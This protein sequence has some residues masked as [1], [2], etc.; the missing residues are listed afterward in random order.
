[1]EQ[2]SMWYEERKFLVE[3]VKFLSDERRDM[4]NT[5]TNTQL[6]FHDAQKEIQ[7]LN[8]HNRWV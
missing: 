6:K 1:M 5:L 4:L 7:Q 3:K 2:R 8:E